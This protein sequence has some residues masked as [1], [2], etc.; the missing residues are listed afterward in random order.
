MLDELFTKLAEQLDTIRIRNYSGSGIKPLDDMLSRFNLEICKAFDELES[1][2]AENQ[3][4]R[5]ELEAL[6]ASNISNT[7]VL[8]A[9]SQMCIGQV[10]MGYSLDAEYI[11]RCIYEATGM[12]SLEL[13][14]H[15]NKLEQDND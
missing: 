8:S 14:E 13:E 6:K 15:A 4:L 11:G 10:T 3:V 5:N 7:K 2:E 12:T 1:L 9:I